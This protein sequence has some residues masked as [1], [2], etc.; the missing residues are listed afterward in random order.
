MRALAVTTPKRD[1][2]LPEVPTLIELGI[3]NFEV[4]NWY[5]IAAPAGTPP[6]IVGRLNAEVAK[7]L[8]LP[9]VSERF[10]GLGIEISSGTPAEFAAFMRA[11]T[12]KWGRIVRESGA[13]VD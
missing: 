9:D 2:Q 12:A 7:V 10:K 5:G 8:R 1:Q 6:E 11:E 4:T 3:K 13:K